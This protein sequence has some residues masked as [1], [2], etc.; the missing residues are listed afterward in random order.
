M[1]KLF[2]ATKIREVSLKNR[3]VMAPMCMYEAKADGKVQPF[4]IVH[5]GSRAVGQVGLIIIEATAVLPEGRITENDLEI[6]RAH[7]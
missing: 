2:E 7:V 6:G 4:H 1:H 3:V 5:Y